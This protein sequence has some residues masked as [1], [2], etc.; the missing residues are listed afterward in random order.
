M[1][2][3][4]LKYIVCLKLNKYRKTILSTSP[5]PILQKKNKNKKWLTSQ[6][7]TQM[8]YLKKYKQ[9]FRYGD[10]MRKDMNS[11]LVISAKIQSLKSS[12]ESILYKL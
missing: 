8:L 2:N 12:S 1:N 3:I 6:P 9:K 11:I 5:M 7:C 10:K 4:V